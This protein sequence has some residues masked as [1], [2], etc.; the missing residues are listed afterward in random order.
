MNKEKS[1]LIFEQGDTSE[2]L[3][4]TGFLGVGTRDLKEVFTYLGFILKGQ[5]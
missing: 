5:V 2:I 1:L 3:F 4:I